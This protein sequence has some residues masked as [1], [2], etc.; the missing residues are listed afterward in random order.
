VIERL[1]D[2]DVRQVHAAV[3][4]VVHDEDV[5]LD[6]VVAVVAHDRFHRR[7]HRAQVS[8]QGQALGDQLALAVGEA[9]RIVHVVLQDARVGRSEDGQ[10]HLV[11]D[12]EDR[13][14]EQLE[15][16]RI[17]GFGHAAMLPGLGPGGNE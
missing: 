3:E 1:E 5:A 6:H 10:G 9:G 7:R 15:G 13:V 2:E 8:R 14:L 11:G 4:R 17:F 12:R 16:D